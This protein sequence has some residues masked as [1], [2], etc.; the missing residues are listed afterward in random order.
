MWKSFTVL[1][2]IITFSLIANDQKVVKGQIL[3]AET[4]ESI[5][6]ASIIDLAINNIWYE[7]MLP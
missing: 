3:D 5:I 2:F 7:N 6:G 1:I 4:K